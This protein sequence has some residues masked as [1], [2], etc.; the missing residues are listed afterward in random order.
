MYVLNL[1]V[2][3]AMQGGIYG[4]LNCFGAVGFISLSLWVQPT[5]YASHSAK[6]M[7]ECD[8][9]VVCFRG[10]HLVCLLY[11]VGGFCAAVGLIRVVAARRKRSVETA[12]FR[13]STWQPLVQ[14]D[15]DKVVLSGSE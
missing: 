7:M 1:F 10:F 11:S 3:A 2:S 6:D 13:A 9:G 4:M 14:N 15:D 5:V 8:A 12:L